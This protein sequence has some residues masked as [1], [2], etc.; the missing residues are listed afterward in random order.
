MNLLLDTHIFISLA[1]R[2]IEVDYPA[3]AKYIEV[4]GVNLIL[5]VA[6]IWE[7]TIKTDI[8][9]L[10]SAIDPQQIELFCTN[11]EIKVLPIKANHASLTLAVVPQ[12]RDPFDRMLLAQCAVEDMKL[13]TV[14]RLLQGHPLVA[15][16]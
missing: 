8:G 6:S 13:V 9:K 11:A 15:Q 5:S 16:I 14:D 10:S 3:H 4:T 2:T 1:R 7:I 12:T